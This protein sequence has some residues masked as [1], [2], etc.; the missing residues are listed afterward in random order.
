MKITKFLIKLFSQR[1]V[2]QFKAFTATKFSSVF[3]GRQLRQVVEWQ[4]KQR[5]EDH[6]S[7]Y[8]FIFLSTLL[9]KI[10]SCVL[11]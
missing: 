8:F 1:R 9:S 2:I 7:Y 3:E 6:V 5:F 10:L 11:P 4:I